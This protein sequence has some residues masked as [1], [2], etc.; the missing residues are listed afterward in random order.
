MSTKVN[1]ETKQAWIDMIHDSI[2]RAIDGFSDM[3]LNINSQS[4]KEVLIDAVCDEVKGSIVPLME[5]VIAENESLWFMLDEMKAAD[6]K[7]NPLIVD[8]LNSVV[9]MNMARIKLM[10]S[11]K[12]EA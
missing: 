10:M 3:Q 8:E 12:G 2:E 7:N 5:D 6:V 4:A 11:Q 1:S 9:D